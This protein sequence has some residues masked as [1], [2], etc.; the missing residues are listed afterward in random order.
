MFTDDPY[1]CGLRARVP[2]FVKATGKHVLPAMTER[3]TLKET[4]VPM[5]VP[6]KRF[7]VAHP[8]GF[9]PQMPFAH[10]MQQALWHARSYESGIGAY[11]RPKKEKLMY[12]FYPDRDRKLRP[13]V[14]QQPR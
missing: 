11:E 7:S 12:Q 6:S 8:H 2:N 3:L 1:Y 5:P 13:M 14:I 10:P 9:P 4:P